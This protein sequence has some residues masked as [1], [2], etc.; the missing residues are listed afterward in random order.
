MKPTLKSYPSLIQ[1][2]CRLVAQI[3]DGGIP[4]V[5]DQGS[6]Y[7]VDLSGGDHSIQWHHHQQIVMGIRGNASVYAGHP[8]TFSLRV[9]KRR[10]GWLDVGGGA[11][12]WE[13]RPFSDPWADWLDQ[14]L[15]LTFLISDVELKIQSAQPH[16]NGVEYWM[17]GR[18]I[19]K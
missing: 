1:P 14:H 10:H 8:E 11:S 13:E 4:L 7:L 12:T 16:R 17:T 2:D 18:R 9:W 5:D 3:S 15:D 6:E 19:K